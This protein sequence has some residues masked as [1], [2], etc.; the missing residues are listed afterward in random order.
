YRLTVPLKRSGPRG[1]GS[2]EAISWNQL[3]TEVA[4]GG[5]LILP[6]GR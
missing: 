3:I 1:S 2:F 5:Y 6:R 4:Q